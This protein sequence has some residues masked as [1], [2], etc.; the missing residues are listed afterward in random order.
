MRNTFVEKLDRKSAYKVIGKV[1]GDRFQFYYAESRKSKN[2][3]Y[4][5]NE[6]GKDCWGIFHKV[7]KYLEIYVHDTLTN[8][9][10]SICMLDGKFVVLGDESINNN[11]HLQISYKKSMFEQFGGSYKRYLHNQL[12]KVLEM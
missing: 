8:H 9:D 5:L 10:T 6:D 1:F 7:E 4:L 3:N 11:K 12:N 2:K